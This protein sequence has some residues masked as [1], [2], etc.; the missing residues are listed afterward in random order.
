MTEYELWLDESGQFWREQ[1]Y[2]AEAGSHSLV[3]GILIEKGRIGQIRD[4]DYPDQDLAHAVNIRAGGSRAKYELILD[5]LLKL[6]KKTGSRVVFF[7]NE[8]YSS[9]YSGKTLYLRMIAEGILA[10]YKDLVRDA[11]KK[12]EDT[13]IHMTVLIATHLA[14][15]ITDDGEGTPA[16]ESAQMVRDREYEVTINKLISE[17]HQM[18]SD[19]DLGKI[20]LEFGDANP[21]HAGTDRRLWFADY[22]CNSR[23]RW[24]RVSNEKNPGLRHKYTQ[25]YSNATVKSLHEKDYI[26]YADG[27]LQ[28]G[29]FAEAV[30]FLFANDDDMLEC[31]IAEIKSH[32]AEKFRN[33]CYRLIKSAFKTIGQ[34]AENIEA[35]TKDYAECG[36]MLSD[37][38]G[39]MT[40]D[41]F[42]STTEAPYDELEF[43][44]RMIISDCFL[45]TGRT[46]LA[47]DEINRCGELISSRGYLLEDLQNIY[48]LAEKK[49][50]M[51]ID[52]FLYDD[53]CRTMSEAEKMFEDLF[54]EGVRRSEYFG[55][56]LCMHLLAIM[57][58]IVGDQKRTEQAR[59]LSNRALKQYP[60]Y[61]GEL[62]RHRQYRSFIE[63]AAGDCAGALQWLGQAKCGKSFMLSDGDRRKDIDLFLNEVV[64]N[65]P[66][67]SRRFYLMYY[68]LIME[69]AYDSDCGEDMGL[70]DE[71]YEALVR[72]GDLLAASGIDAAELGVSVPEN[73][74]YP[75]QT[76]YWKMAH[77]LRKRAGK[78]DAGDIDA[79][80]RMFLAAEKAC[81]GQKDLRTVAILS[82]R[83]G[84]LAETGEDSGKMSDIYSRIRDMIE[85]LHNEPLQHDNK[86]LI[87]MKE[88]IDR[89]ETQPG[90]DRELLL[91]TAGMLPY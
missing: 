45:R 73:A 37:M 66:V 20:K 77:I 51:Q 60:P 88:N 28:E 35:D 48:Q 76:I 38:L 80:G 84:F 23:F 54:H 50:L 42:R 79:A 34:K 12:G 21:E 31:E 68:L 40:Q 4:G 55:D 81:S 25:L 36:K 49:A 3:G 7:E 6:K 29:D 53:A 83:L 26:G 41:A 2:K 85:G 89:A 32:I 17:K 64:K 90:Y 65:E 72:N 19:I 91:K 87:S 44:V 52:N 8:S 11:R 47:F 27:E 18:Y 63:A 70:A 82:E 13:D 9:Y 69:M 22:A 33:M 14:V 74:G 61:E 78:T 39:Y 15:D 75:L 30:L 43:K 5:C 56:A 1:E 86:L 71:M 16:Q 24:R 67:V 57:P 58:G 46:D 59:V 62:E 10:L